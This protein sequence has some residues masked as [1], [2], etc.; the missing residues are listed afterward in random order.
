MKATF[1]SQKTCH[2][3][4]QHFTYYVAMSLS[5]RIWAQPVNLVSSMTPLLF[6]I[7]VT[8]LST[9][10]CTNFRSTL[11]SQHTFLVATTC[12]SQNT[13]NNGPITTHSLR[14][15]GL[16]D[17]TTKSGSCVSQLIGKMFHFCSGILPKKLKSH[18]AG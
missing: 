6:L 4:L 3:V 13:I 2:P 17:M 5:Q 8:F 15:M 12:H 14:P 16:R 10:P 1:K 9:F 18:L 11:F 7:L